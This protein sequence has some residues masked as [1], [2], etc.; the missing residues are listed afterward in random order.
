MFYNHPKHISDDGIRVFRRFCKPRERIAVDVLF[1]VPGC[2]F[3]VGKAECTSILPDG[4]AAIHEP[5]MHDVGLS[6][7]K[8]PNAE[9]ERLTAEALF[10]LDAING[11]VGVTG[12]VHDH[13]VIELPGK[14]QATWAVYGHRC[15]LGPDARDVV[16]GFQGVPSHREARLTRR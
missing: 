16:D 6:R 5:P 14:I 4:T 10:H 9:L 11:V 13:V 15:H 2:R 8:A 12:N 1:K 7:S 3:H